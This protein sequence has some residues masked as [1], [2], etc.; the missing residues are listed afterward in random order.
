[1]ISVENIQKQSRIKIAFNK[2]KNFIFYDF[3]H[4]NVWMQYKPIRR[5]FY[6]LSLHPIFRFLTYIVVI[7]NCIILSLDQYPIMYKDFDN[8]V[9]F[10]NLIFHIF[11]IFEQAIKLY[12]QGFKY[13]QN[14]KIDLFDFVITCIS[15]IKLFFNYKVL[16][17]LPSLR[18]LRL[19][20]IFLTKNDRGNSISI[21]TATFFDIVPVFLSFSFVFL[22]NSYIFS[23]I[24][25][26]IF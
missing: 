11:F 23:I 14:D 17:A 15:S 18:V 1:M 4:K 3:P 5:F 19:F 8:K 6:K 20:R 26:N 16:K 10:V 2:I 22:I 21:L 25:M 13:L 24:G 9:Y 7:S 12:G